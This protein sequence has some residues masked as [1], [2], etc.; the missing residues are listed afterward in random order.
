MYRP[1]SSGRNSTL[2]GTDMPEWRNVAN[3]KLKSPA[4]SWKLIPY[5]SE[6]VAEYP[7]QVRCLI[8]SRGLQAGGVYEASGTE[9][10]CCLVIPCI[11]RNFPRADL[12]A[13]V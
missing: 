6:F 13:L 10:D 7:I 1:T 11:D 3:R 9:C 4:K 5:G 12:E 2:S 8:S